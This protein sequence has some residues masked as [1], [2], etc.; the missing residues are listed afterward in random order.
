MMRDTSCD[1]ALML[2]LRKVFLDPNVPGRRARW[3]AN[4][5]SPLILDIVNLRVHNAWRIRPEY[6]STG[7]PNLSHLVSVDR[8]STFAR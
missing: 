6:F 1:A 5:C 7:L 8:A 2:V 3:R 4:Y